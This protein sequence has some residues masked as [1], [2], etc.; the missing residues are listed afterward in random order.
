VDSFLTNK[1][2]PMVGIINNAG[3]PMRLPIETISLDE[4]KRVFEVNFFGSLTMT[5]KF[6]PLIRKHQGRI[7]FISTM[8]VYSREFGGGIYSAS[9]CAMEALL[10]SLR[11]EMEPLG[12]SVTSV[13]PGF[14]KTPIDAKPITNFREE[15]PPALYD[16]YEAYFTVFPAIRLNAFRHAPG[17]E[18]T[19]EVI[20]DAITNPYPRTRY[21]PGS[22][23]LLLKW[24]GIFPDRLVDHLRPNYNITKA[25]K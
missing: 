19:S 3:I 11:L 13:L 25:I 10:D 15:M 14:V 1:G 18:V 23:P 12:V 6:L 22:S 21:Y 2:L 7:L 8:A 5:Q 20:V 24:V 4:V 17:P 16:L 9:K